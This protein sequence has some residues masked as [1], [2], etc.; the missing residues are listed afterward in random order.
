MSASSYLESSPEPIKAVLELSLVSRLVALISTSIPGLTL[1]AP[2]LFSG[3][4]SSDG[5]SFLEEAE[6]CIIEFGT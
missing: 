4:S 5:D 2:D 3:I 6:T 1:V